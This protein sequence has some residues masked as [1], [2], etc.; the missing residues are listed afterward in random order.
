MSGGK[1]ETPRQKMIGM[2]YLVLTALLALNVSADI[3]NAFIIVNESIEETNK[4]LEQKVEA[5]YAAF[6][7]ALAEN[8]AKTKSQYEKVKKIKDYSDNLVN[9][10][11]DVKDELISLTEG[12]SIEQAK[13]TG[14]KDLKAKDNF[15]KPTNYFIGQS[16]DGSQGKARE[17][18]N[19]IIEFKENVLKTLDERER[20]LV[21]LGL[22]VEGNDFKD[23][24]GMKMNWE[25]YTFYHQILAAA[26]VL[27]NKTVADVRTA[28]ADVISQLYSSI[29]AGDFKFNKIAAKVVPNS[30][31]LIQ[32]EEFTADIFVAAFDTIVSPEVIIG[33]GID[34]NTLEVKGTPETLEGEGGI[35]TYRATASSIGLQTYGGKILVKSPMGGVQEYPFWGEYIVAAPTATVSADKMNVFYIGVDNPVSVSVPGVPNDKVN[36]SI[37]NGRMSSN[38]GGKY[39]VRVES[40]FDTKVN[41]SADMGGQNR[42]MGSFEFR[43]RKVPDPVAYIAGIR[44]G[45]IPKANLIA[46]SVIIPKLEN[47]EFDLNFIVTSFTFVMSMA[48]NELVEKAATGNKLTQ[49]MINMI[50]NAKRGQKCYIENI[51]AKGPDGRE[52]SLGTISLRIV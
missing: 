45:N 28:E 14:V 2:M 27:L 5:N 32:G 52:R 41:V 23:L 47:F 44:E 1:K 10:I 25:M 31:F 18:K 4:V 30:K 12:I 7:K 6:E 36:V 29:D 26:V 19:K 24:S 9:Y 11:K 39:T 48:G 33:S 46:S 51:K 40:G 13:E 42:S 15:D 3:L 35:V 17:L 38:G 20:S 50:Q 34:T 43:V 16:S 37:S 8:P 21:K 49:D 22:N